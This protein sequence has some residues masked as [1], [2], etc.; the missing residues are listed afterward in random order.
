M[1]N[2]STH[3]R[4]PVIHRRTNPI[5]HQLVKAM[6]AEL[7]SFQNA[8]YL[9]TTPILTRRINLPQSPGLEKNLCFLETVR[10]Q[11]VVRATIENDFLKT[12]VP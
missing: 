7:V 4:S 2:F 12:P 5:H 9:K 1:K 8:G 10:L 3:R 6:S 11:C